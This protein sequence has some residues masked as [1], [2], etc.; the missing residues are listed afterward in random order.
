M[1]RSPLDIEMHDAVEDCWNTFL[2][3]RKENGKKER[4]EKSKEVIKLINHVTTLTSATPTTL[5]LRIQV[6][7]ITYDAG[8]EGA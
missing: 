4:K 8:I 7:T 2:K 3:K 5:G 1:M 6:Y